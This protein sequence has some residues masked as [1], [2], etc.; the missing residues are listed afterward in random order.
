MKSTRHLAIAAAVLAAGAIAVLAWQSL[1]ARTQAPDVTYMR[2]D[3]TKFQGRDLLGKVVLVNFWAT[4]CTTCVKEMPQIT[5]THRKYQARGFE[6][7]AVA[8]SYDMPLHI[9]NFAKSREL[10][11]TV[12]F[13]A[14][15]D[16]AKQYGSVQ[17][18]PT[19]FLLNKRGEVVKQVVGEPDFPA[20]HRLI[21]ELVADT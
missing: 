3:G 20:L 14:T 1:G 10:P 4:S 8:M 18:T 6:T 11:F 15:G 13:D 5:A 21:E 7:V 9:V 12:V 16:I 17:L 2:I 19:T